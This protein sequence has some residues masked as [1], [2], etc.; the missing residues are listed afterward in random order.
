MMIS[1]KER[2]GDALELLAEGLYPPFKQE[3]T[4]KYS[5]QWQEEAQ[6]YITKYKNM[7]KRELEERLSQDIGA[8][9][10]VISNKWDSIFKN[11]ENVDNQHRGIIFE[12]IQLRNNWAHGNEF[13]HRY[14]ERAIDNM[15]LLLTAFQ[16]ENSIINQL[17]QHQEIMLSKIIEDQ[18]MDPDREKKLRR[19]LSKLL[20]KIPFQ[21]VDL[22]NHALTHSSYLYEHPK[23]VKRDNELLEFLGDSVLNFISGEYLY[24]KY[25]SGGNEGD[26]TKLRSALVENK[27]L[28]KFAEKLALQQYI[29][30]GKG[31]ALN[32]SLLSNTFEAMI[33]ACFLDSGMK[34]VQEFLQ[35][36]FDSVIAE[37]TSLSQGNSG[38]VAAD[39]KNRLQEWVQKN[40]GPITP[41]YETIKE[42]GADHKKQFTV[43]VMVQGK[44]YGE[45]KGS[46]KKEASKKAAEKALGK[47]D[48]LGL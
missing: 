2:I 28:A 23:E 10:Q 16:A 3:M 5:D 25:K 45:G 12:L 13:S 15:V 21:N 27:Q 40:I 32:P 24:H 26:L 9:L 7:K 36:L 48:K 37:I 14:T 34:K 38:K 33:G 11:N 4:N 39:S 44:V 35:P 20:K 43:Q 42:E 31:V 47:I 17:K 19:E 8:L 22:L 18:N 6:K 41:E 1:N 29:R 46:S 30:L